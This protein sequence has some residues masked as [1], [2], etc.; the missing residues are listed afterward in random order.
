MASS[1]LSAPEAPPAA[2]Y[3]P[4]GIPWG[5]ILP[6][7]AWAWTIWACA[8]HWQANPNYSYG[9][10]VP[11]LALG[12]ALRR[13]LI[14]GWPETTTLAGGFAKVSPASILLALTGAALVFL[15]EF[16]REQI[17]HPII[18]IWTIAFLAIVLT[19]AVLWLE[20]GPRL[21]RAELFPVL[22]F[23]T[24]VPWPPRI[25][26]PITSTL[27]RWVALAT[28]EVLQWLG[29]EAQASGGAI[30][31]RTGLVGITE[32]CSGIRSLQ[33]GVMFGLAM[34]EWFLLSSARRIVL[35][36]LA[37]AFALATN[38]A[39]TLA[40]TL[41]A[42][43]HGIEAVDRVHDLIGNIIITA[44]VLAI[45]LT[46]KLLA[47][48]SR[49]AATAASFPP[50]LAKLRASLF[51]PA[52]PLFAV[53]LACS[54]GGLVAARAV[55]AHIEAKDATQTSPFFTAKLNSSTGNRL[56]RIPRTVWNELHPTSGEYIRHD[57]GTTAAG[58]AD[59]FHFF[60]KPS[61]WNRFALVHRPDIC[62][63][64]VGWQLDGPAE[65]HEARLDGHALRFYLFRF[66]R[67]ATN[68]L[69]LWGAWR[70][71]E[72][73]PIDYQPDQ[74]L[75]TAPPPA[76][77]HLAG[78]RRSATEIVSCSIITE[79]RQP[80]PELAVEILRSVFTYNP[81]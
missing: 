14:G 58:G 24:A 37:I 48:S 74:I 67:G 60:W 68:A 28:T 12:F 66:H 78:K 25:E 2:A 20:G 80:S 21:A 44:L 72:A 31:L 33:A 1:D 77:L 52:R 53:I 42:N 46:G 34:G 3:P 27:M 57:A 75:G 4:R 45:W 19:F 11:L 16:A 79:N 15:L 50:R 73:V 5:L 36:L 70:N 32:A 56:G 81:R 35:L 63:P 18:V 69:E 41:Q 17:L 8:E 62:M 9:W 76:S 49:R 29:I 51:K 47:R 7:A 71:G 59:C 39:R 13:Y 55:T 38:L 65:L 43:E 23:L 40:L 64:G 26:Q 22:F 54:L 30:A 61:P 10:A 6:A